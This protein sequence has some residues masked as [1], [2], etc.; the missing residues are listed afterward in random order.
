[1]SDK[2]DAS[3]IV[4]SLQLREPRIVAAP[5]GCLPV[6][7]QVVAFRD[8]G[9]CVGSERLE[10]EHRMIDLSC[11]LARVAELGLV[12]NKSRIGG[13]ALAGNDREHEGI[14]YVGVGRGV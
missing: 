10:R 2:E 3:W 13:L 6:R 4:Y 14:K 5:I 12:A 11:F 9:A 1:M 7:L 8:I